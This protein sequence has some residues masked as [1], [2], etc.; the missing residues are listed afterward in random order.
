M[1][2]GERL[3]HQKRLLESEGHVGGGRG[4][5]GRRLDR[6]EAVSR[7]SR[8]RAARREHVKN[9]CVSTEKRGVMQRK[10]L[11]GSTVA[12]GFQEENR[13]GRSWASIDDVPKHGSGNNDLVRR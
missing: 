9:S 11:R 13:I 4:H 3:Q 2:F 8:S 12:Q 5:D 7:R 10:T 1:P 6:G